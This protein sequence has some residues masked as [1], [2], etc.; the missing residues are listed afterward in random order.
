MSPPAAHHLASRQALHQYTPRY[1]AYDPRNLPTRTVLWFTRDEIQ[2]LK[3]LSN[4]NFFLLFLS[5][6]ILVI[7]VILAAMG[8]YPFTEAAGVLIHKT[9]AVLLVFQ[10]LI[11][12]LGYLGIQS[13]SSCVIDVYI[14]FTVILVVL[15]ILAI[16]VFSFFGERLDLWF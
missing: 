4:C 13:E 3:S 12:L 7:I 8:A 1:K 6:F 11:S 10:I 9:Y 16:V 2:T 15:D 14:A 5:L